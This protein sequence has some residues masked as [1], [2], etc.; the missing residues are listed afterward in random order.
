VRSEGMS[1]TS[2]PASRYNEATP[3]LRTTQLR[4]AKVEEGRI[5]ELV[6]YRFESLNTEIQGKLNTTFQ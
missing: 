6:K 1:Q 4:N 5:A 3:E 2:T